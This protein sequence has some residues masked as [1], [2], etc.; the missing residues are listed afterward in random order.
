[1]HLRNQEV[2]VINENGKAVHASQ[3]RRIKKQIQG[4]SS[5]PIG[6]RTSPGTRGKRQPA[7]PKSQR[8]ARFN[9]TTKIYHDGNKSYKQPAKSSGKGGTN[10]N[11]TVFSANGHF[12]TSRRIAQ[13]AG[14][15]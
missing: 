8:S 15:Q 11:P 7:S 1:M 2:V 6:T 3:A 14:G 12:F 4:L 5:S 10:K 9:E 13:T